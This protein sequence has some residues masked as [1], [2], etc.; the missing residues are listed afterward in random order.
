MQHN[1]FF[2]VKGRSIADIIVYRVW[3][4]VNVRCIAYVRN[5]TILVRKIV[6]REDKLKFVLK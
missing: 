4:V 6:L 5:V 2:I 3:H 1:T